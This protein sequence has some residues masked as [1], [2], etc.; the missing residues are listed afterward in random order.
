MP[1]STRNKALEDTTSQLIYALNHPLRRR[2]L[3]RLIRGPASA[4]M[5]SKAL[6]EPLGNISYHLGDVLKRCGALLIAEE[7]PRRG[8]RETLYRVRASF[9]LGGI[10]WPAIPEPLRSGLRGVALHDFLEA[11]IASL[12]ADAAPPKEG[13][14]PREDNGYYLYRPVAA[15]MDGQREINEAAEEFKK[16]VEAV[17]ARCAVVNPADLLSLIVGISSFE[18]AP[19]PKRKRKR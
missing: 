3:K 19:L 8:A 18:A 5:L 17:E 12:E 1:E 16:K 11:A 4:S 7:V 9:L 13:N 6:G 10:D 15:D 2:I 14:R